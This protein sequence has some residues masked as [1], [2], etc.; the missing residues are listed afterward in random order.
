MTEN[1]DIKPDEIKDSILSNSVQGNTESVF[2]DK[3]EKDQIDPEVSARNFEV[4]VDKM[5]DIIEGIKGDFV[6]VTDD[7]GLIIKKENREEIIEKIAV[8]NWSPVYDYTN[9]SIERNGYFINSIGIKEVYSISDNDDG[10]VSREICGE[11]VN[12]GDYIKFVTE[13]GKMLNEKK[14]QLGISDY[15]S[16]ERLPQDIKDE[17]KKIKFK[18]RTE[19]V[20]NQGEI[21][22]PGFIEFKY[23]PYG[24]THFGSGTTDGSVIAYDLKEWREGKRVKKIVV[25][26][27]GDNG[28]VSGPVGATIDSNTILICKS[29]DFT[30]DQV[31]TREEIY[32]CE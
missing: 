30:D 3:V 5:R 17:V 21:V 9:N 25:T 10:S 8:Y 4:A 24:D 19:Y 27:D 31:I 16:L 7:N 15:V 1:F 12:S 18:N 29:R 13:T 32:I 11:S 6:G 20:L 2:E 28:F 26:K 23:G 22:T 14:Q